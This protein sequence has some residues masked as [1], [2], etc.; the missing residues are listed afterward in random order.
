M[1]VYDFSQLFNFLLWGWSRDITITTKG[2]LSVKF[3]ENLSLSETRILWHWRYFIGARFV[4]PSTIKTSVSIFSPMTL[5]CLYCCISHREFR[6]SGTWYYAR[7]ERD[8]F[9]YDCFFRK[10][11]TLFVFSEGIFWRLCC[12]GAYGIA[13]SGVKVCHYSFMYIHGVVWLTSASC[14]RF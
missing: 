11:K 3:G 9:G 7:T 14:T 4:T 10:R 5:R 12:S 13:S 2:S 8:W 1:I 6:S